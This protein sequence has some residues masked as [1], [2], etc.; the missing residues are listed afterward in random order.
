MGGD[1]TP[2]AVRAGGLMAYG[3]DVRVSPQ[4]VAARHTLASGA[5]LGRD[6][7]SLVVLHQLQW[8]GL[9]RGAADR[10]NRSLEGFGSGREGVL[11]TGVPSTGPLSRLRARSPA[12][13][14]PPQS[15]R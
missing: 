3:P 7:R 14:N 1:L 11:R 12:T 10:E 2:S 8:P 5:I 9:Y 6:F 4:R 15:P 13:G